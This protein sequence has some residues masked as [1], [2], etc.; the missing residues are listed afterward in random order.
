MSKKMLLDVDDE[1]WEKFKKN[2]TR[3]KNLNQA[4]VELIKKD[5]EGDEKELDKMNFETGIQYLREDID[6]ITLQLIKLVKE[7]MILIEKIARLKKKFD[8]PIEDKKRE[9]EMMVNI[10][11]IVDRENKKVGKKLVNYLTVQEIMNLLLRDSKKI[12]LKVKSE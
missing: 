5:L 1:L 4:I 10:K 8:K 12:L 6:N 2:V 9:S 3:D 11:K 7:R